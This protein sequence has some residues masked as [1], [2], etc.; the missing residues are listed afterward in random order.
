ME[1]YRDYYGAW[2]QLSPCRTVHRYLNLN[3]EKPKHL[4]QLNNCKKNVKRIVE[5]GFISIDSDKG[6]RPM[7]KQLVSQSYRQR[8]KHPC[9][10]KH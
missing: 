5:N 2:A 8:R 6:G 7:E 3:W 4:L 10:N 1:L 9:E